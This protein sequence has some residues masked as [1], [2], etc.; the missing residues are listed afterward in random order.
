M[1]VPASI[2][3]LQI[4][5]ANNMIF[6][7]VGIA[8]V[9]S[10]FSLLSAKA[11]FGESNYQR[12]VL[13]AR[14]TAVDKLKTNVD[15][16][17]KLKQQYDTF[18][19]QNPNI[20]GGKGGLD[21]A[22]ALSKG[23]DQNGTVTVN[24]QP[25]TLST[26]DGDNAKIVL[27]ALPSRYD[28]PALISSIEKIANLDHAPL[29]SVVGTDESNTGTQDGTTSNTSASQTDSQTLPFSITTQTDYSTAQTLVKDLERSIRPFDI[30]RFSIHGNGG[31]MSET[32]EANTNYQQPISLQIK[33]KEVP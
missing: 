21:L 14:H 31:S 7:A 29:Q 27:D 4:H 25:I 13:S 19:S 9:V 30:I 28:F 32:I 15:E 1:Q 11:L 26:Q 6:I 24:G 12:K 18:E 10:V 33:E 8:T 5:K 2:K 3:H 22:I 23:Q 16:A 20:I 17:K